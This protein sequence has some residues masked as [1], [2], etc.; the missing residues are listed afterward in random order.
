ML[1]VYLKMYKMLHWEQW[2][3]VSKHTS[4]TYY[5]K[6]VNDKVVFAYTLFFLKIKS[7]PSC[8]NLDYK[9]LSPKQIKLWTTNISHNLIN[10]RKAINS[11]ILCF[12]P[13]VNKFIF[14]NNK[15][16]IHAEFQISSP[17][18]MILTVIIAKKN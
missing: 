4:P 7:I 18:H 9:K 5:V 11:E 13:V 3:T 16:A 1:A 8:N 14:K 6:I 17:S 10:I 12:R 15:R 2:T